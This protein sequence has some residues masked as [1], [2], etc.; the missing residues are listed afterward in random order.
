MAPDC[1]TSLPRSSSQDGLVQQVLRLLKDKYNAT[2]WPS[3]T[4]DFDTDKR[5]S[6]SNQT[7]Q[8]L[9]DLS[10][11]AQSD[12]L[13]LPLS[14]WAFWG[15]FLSNASEI[16]VNAPPH[17]QVLPGLHQYIYHK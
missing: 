4:T 15:G 6:G 11:L 2:R 3:A 14:S 7:K 13:I 17:N 1:P 16:H 5:S 8:L 10:A 9:H 12:K